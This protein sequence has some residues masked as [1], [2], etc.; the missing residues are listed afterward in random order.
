MPDKTSIMF[1]DDEIAVLDGLRRQLHPFKSIWD[2][3]FVSS[4]VEA[5]QSFEKD[6]VDVVITDLKMPHISGDTMANLFGSMP[7]P[8]AIIVLS[9]HS[10]YAEL[11]DKIT[12]PFEYLSKPCD[13]VLLVKTVSNILHNAPSRISELYDE[14]L[15]VVVEKLRDHNL[16]KLEDLPIE[17][18]TLLGIR[19]ISEY[20]GEMTFEYK[21]DD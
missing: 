1:L 21:E 14:V 7:K 6:P 5:L 3:R 19:K 2:M 16:L 18:T 12:V 4:P 11:S 20:L 17:Y 9:G 13:P 10:S 15:Q 8:P